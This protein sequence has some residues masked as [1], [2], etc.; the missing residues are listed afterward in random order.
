MNLPTHIGIIMDGN[1]RWAQRRG[2][3]RV[4]G[5]KAGVAALEKIVEHCGKLGIPYLTVFAFS[6]ENWRRPA[7]E[8]RAI[9]NLLSKTAEEKLPKLLENNVQTRFMGRL[10]QFPIWIRRRLYRVQ[11]ATKN[12]T[13]LI[14][15]IALNY[16]GRSE[17]VDAVNKILHNGIRKVDEETFRR[18][19]YYPDLPDI[20]LLIRT[21]GEFR[22][23]NF[24]L[25]QLAYTELWITPTLWPDFTP[26]ELDR[27]IADYTK[28]ERRYGGLIQS[29]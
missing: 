11:E 12:N 28:R 18:F 21:S 17:I 15:T 1:G 19:L 23:S 10:N 3:P 27:A 14:F 5:H 20:D 2:L 7:H 22:I 26:E 8:V 16:G 29:Q 13:G 24:M 25:W 9:L 4:E 6:T